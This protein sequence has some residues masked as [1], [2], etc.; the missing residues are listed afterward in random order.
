ML[1]YVIVLTVLGSGSENTVGDF[2][3]DDADSA[4]I[5]PNNIPSAY[6]GVPH[7]LSFRRSDLG[8]LTYYPR[9]A[10]PQI[11]FS[12][13]I[14]MP[15]PGPLFIMAENGQPPLPHDPVSLSSA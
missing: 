10:R 1:T 8:A 2:D 5:F 11:G 3:A 12:S 4:Q 9:M 15:G 7:Q 13:Y 6:I 14:N